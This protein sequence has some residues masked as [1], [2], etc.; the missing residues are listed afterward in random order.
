MGLVKLVIGLLFVVPAVALGQTFG[1]IETRNQR[2]LLLPFLR[3]E[4][5]NTVL[6]EGERQ[7]SF[8]YTLSNDFRRIPSS[9]GVPLLQEDQET[10]RIL[11]DYRKG[12]RGGMEFGIQIPV[13][14]RGGGILDPMIDWWHQNV[15]QWSDPGRNS[16]A[17]GGSVVRFPG[18][19]VYGSATGLGDV[20]VML[21]KRL[22]RRTIATAAAKLPTGDSGKLF[23]SGNVDGAFSLYYNGA[24]NG[25]WSYSLQG[26][27]VA[28]GK[29]R[30]F[31]GAR[32]LVHQEAIALIYS[33]NNRDAWIGQWQGDSAAIQ[34][35]L[36]ESD[37]TQRIITFGYQRRL[38][39]SQRLDLFFSEDRDLFSGQWPE[40]ANIGPDFT[41]G[42]RLNVRF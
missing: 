21:S 24:V 14:N 18:G 26:G 17:F 2:A 30:D 41:L 12:I 5:R 35:G 39:A 28:Q 6:A 13:L 27:F 22:D 9:G 15:L 31:D 7:W 4:P 16:T 40:G 29:A 25:R 11:F 34:T 8:S 20:S 1:P 33:P 23:G 42:V 37:A 3:L 10:S 38:S 19:G 36:A 32:G